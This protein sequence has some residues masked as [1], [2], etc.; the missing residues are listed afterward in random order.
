MNKKIYLRL[1]LSILFATIRFLV[2][3]KVSAQ[4]VIN[5]ILSNPAGSEAGAE[6][7]ELYNLSN[8]VTPL[9]GCTLYL[10]ETTSSQRIVFREEDFIDKYKVISWDNAWLNN[11]G[12]EIR[13][14]CAS[15]TDI[16]SYG[17]VQGAVLPPPKDGISFGRFPDGTGGFVML[18]YP[19][20]G[21]SNSTPS[22]SP[23][24]PTP[25]PNPT[26]TPLPTPRLTSL[27]TQTPTSIPTKIVTPRPTQEKNIDDEKIKTE[28]ALGVQAVSSE[29]VNK[30]SEENKNFGENFSLALVLVILGLGI[31]GVSLFKIFKNK[32]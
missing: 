6:W 2:P 11:S 19:T 28:D 31:I 18:S 17:N 16:V 20:A 9:Y 1:V 5:E 3:I 23:S 29:V 13:L 24:T 22:A 8:E 15:Q 7:V 21:E 10:D 12:D 30:A 26:N 25:S 27:P 32:N 4:V 14:T